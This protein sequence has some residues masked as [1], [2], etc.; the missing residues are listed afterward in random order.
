M[1]QDRFTVK[2][3][4]AVAAAQR[5]AAE[6]RNPEVAPAHLLLALLDQEDGLVVP[7]LQKVGADVASIRA[8]TLEAVGGLPELGGDAE[9]E[10]RP[11]QTFVRAIQR[12]EREAQA[13][14]DSYISSEHLLL[15][16][17]DK[18]SPVADILPARNDVAAAIKEV[19]PS[20]ITSPTPEDTVQAL[21]KF[22][23]DLTAEAEQGKL[24]PVLGRDQEIRRVIQVLSRRTKNNPVLIGD[25]GVGKTAIVEGLAQ[26][27]V[28]GDVPQSLRDRRV[29][30]LDIRALV[31]G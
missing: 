19:R 9:P 6:R 20:P 8:Q 16:L 25:P 28:A 1:Q 14:G 22:G 11:A 31:A 29:I 13:M 2:S 30:A 17:T 24:D 10:V 5:L 15:A 7:V 18:S 21:Q 23:R 3:Q 26:R 4:E 27:I 12:A